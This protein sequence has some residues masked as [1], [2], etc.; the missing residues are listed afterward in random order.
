[1]TTT[2]LL[3]IMLQILWRLL[4]VRPG[5]CVIGPR[6]QEIFTVCLEQKEQWPQV[7]TH[8]V[9]TMPGKFAEQLNQQDSPN[10]P[11]RSDTFDPSM[12]ISAEDSK[13]LNACQDKRGR[14]A[15]QA[16]VEREASR[17]TLSDI[18]QHAHDKQAEIRDA[19]DLEAILLVRPHH[20]E[21][22]CALA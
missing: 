14:V 11:A 2:C 7:F 3:D 22:Y 12:K 5:V 17:V 6:V 19:A 9:K 16:L 10:A 20:A 4:H 15:Q 13:A 8:L 18:A 1:M 21:V